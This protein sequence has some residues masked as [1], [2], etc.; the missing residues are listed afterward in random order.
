MAY[1]QQVLRRMGRVVANHERHSVDRVLDDYGG[2]L[3]EA[4][5]RAPRFTAHVNVLM[6]T[7]GYFSGQLTS[8]EK[9]LFLEYLEQYRAERIPLS[10]VVSV[11]R[12]WIV[13]FDDAYLMRQTYFEPYPAALVE[14]TDSGKGR[15]Y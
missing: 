12:A 13:R 7:M 6:H 5:A 1:N 11:M 2:H 10:A 3:A 9:E 4:L 15:S 14:I 8:Q